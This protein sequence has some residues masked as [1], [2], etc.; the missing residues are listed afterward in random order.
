MLVKLLAQFLVSFQFSHC[1][2]F[3]IYASHFLIFV[4]EDNDL[5]EEHI[6][7]SKEGFR[8][9][10]EEGFSVPE[11]V[12]MEQQAQA[13]KLDKFANFWAAV[14]NVL[15]SNDYSVAEE[16]RHGE[17]TWISPLCVS[18]RD[19]MSKCETKMEEM[20]PGS[21]TNFIPSY[22]YFRLQFVPRNSHSRVSK[23][24]YGRFDVKF[25]LQKRTLHKAHVDQH[26]GAKQF[27][28]LKIMAGKIS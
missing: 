4:L 7:E 1:L 17:T 20:F 23:R 21:D 8:F 16:R 19:L 9:L 10:L 5:S 6:Q 3:V 28:F 22:E 27:E 14:T 24:Y 2:C 11:A 15:A 18:M 12:H 13:A 26:Y 25:G